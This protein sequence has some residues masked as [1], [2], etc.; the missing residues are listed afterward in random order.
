MEKKKFIK[1][2][3]VG[4]KGLLEIIKASLLI[5][6]GHVTQYQPPRGTELER[7]GLR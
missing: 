2:K 5:S 3:W 7:G 1:R 6:R 4:K